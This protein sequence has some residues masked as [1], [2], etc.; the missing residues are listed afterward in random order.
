MVFEMNELEIIP[1]PKEE[2]K[3][4]PILMR[5]TTEDVVMPTMI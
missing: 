2:W 4:T 5:N 1:L 3:G